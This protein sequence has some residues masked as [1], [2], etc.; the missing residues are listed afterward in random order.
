MFDFKNLV[1]NYSK[2]TT[3]ALIKSEGYYDQEKG[4]I[5]VPGEEI[6]LILIPAAIV[7]LSNDDLK[8]DEGGNYSYDNRK[9]YCYKQ[10]EK[11]TLIENIQSYGVTKT[12]KILGEK[13]YSDYDDGLYIYIVERADRDDKR[14]S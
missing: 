6:N 2:G 10:L 1:A 7:P 5:Y 4:G 3:K 14:T 8:F 9:L 12:Y 11:G 13:D